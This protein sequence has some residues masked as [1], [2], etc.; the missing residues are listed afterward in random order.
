MR[1]TKTKPNQLKGVLKPCLSCG[2]DTPFRSSVL[3]GKRICDSCE[4]KVL[5]AKIWHDAHMKNKRLKK[6]SKPRGRRGSN[7]YRRK[8]K[9]QPT[10][11]LVVLT[12]LL[13]TLLYL[14]LN[15][16]LTL[17]D[18]SLPVHEAEAFAYVSPVAS[19]SATQATPTPSVTAEQPEGEVADFL[20]RVH[21]KESSS[22]TNTNP[23]ALHNRCKAQGKSNSYGYGGMQLMICFDSHEQA[24]AR[25]ARWFRE[26]RESRTE[27]QTYCYYAYGRHMDTCDYW[28]EVRAW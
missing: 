16:L 1:Y 25:V 26:H 8:P 11:L 2:K 20:R 24:T 7:Q 12:V 13:A 5:E 4:P 9:E 6:A 14:A 15:G 23:Q 19:P 22:G 28:E 10:W 27:A 17:D 3:P 18:K 21:R